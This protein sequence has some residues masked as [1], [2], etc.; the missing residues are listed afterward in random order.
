MSKEIGSDS[1]G[2]EA[3]PN[4][5]NTLD[6]DESKPAKPGVLA[7]RSV[8]IGLVV[9]AEDDSARVALAK[10]YI[11]SRSVGAYVDDD[12]AGTRTGTKAITI[13]LQTGTDNTDEDISLKSS[14]RHYLAT[15]VDDSGNI[16]VGT[17]EGV[18]IYSYTYEDSDG[19][20]VTEYVRHSETVSTEM[21]GETIFEYTYQRV[22]VARGVRLPHATDYDHIHFGIW[23]SLAA[24]DEDTGEH[25]V[26]ELGIAFLQNFTGGGMTE[27][28][29]NNGTGTYA[30]NW[31]AHVQE[32]DPEGDGDVSRESGDA[33]MTADFRMGTIDIDL[34]GLASLEADITG[35]TFTGTEA[36]TID[37]GDPY[38]L[39]SDG[40]FTG[41]VNGG[42]F[43]DEAA[44]AGGVFDYASEDN[45]GG[46][47]RGGFGGRRI[48]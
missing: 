35:S 18:M 41:S 42:F 14:G 27:E 3:V 22:D 36:P 13:T 5:A 25:G 8:S 28:M 6:V 1:P 21:D 44:E 24:N 43:G 10:S 32:A 40:K 26:S 39:E 7:G 20:D 15:A 16:V 34:T 9:D 48:D 2:I 47:F 31:V 23:A 11:G 45:E 17:E 33:A 29:P 38:D 4:D 12:T 46:A 30:G 37:A 19:D